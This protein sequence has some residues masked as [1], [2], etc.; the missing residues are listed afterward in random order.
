LLYGSF[1]RRTGKF[2]RGKR[3]EYDFSTN[4]GQLK[5]RADEQGGNRARQNTHCLKDS[6]KPDVSHF[7]K[8]VLQ[9]YCKTHDNRAT[10]TADFK[11]VMEKRL[12]KCM[13]LD[14]NQKM[15]W[16]FDHSVYGTGIP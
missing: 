11:S 2:A 7:F 1:R 14:G 6:R 15:D 10:S 12:A 5:V 9:D 3:L 4:D 8:D 16:F 13:D